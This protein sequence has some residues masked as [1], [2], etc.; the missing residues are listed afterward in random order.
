MPIRH[1]P[2]HHEKKETMPTYEFWCD[3]CQKTVTLGLRLEAFEKKDDRCPEC[4]SIDLKQLIS[5][6]Q[7][8]T[9]RKR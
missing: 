4:R 3:T 8:K 9:S 1:F 7:T 5:T 2:H 6:F